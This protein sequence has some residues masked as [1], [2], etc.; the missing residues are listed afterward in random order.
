MSQPVEIGTLPNTS[1]ITI[2]KLLSLGIK[3]SS[4]LLNYF[5]SRYEN[6]SLIS[7]IE[8]SRPG[9]TVT[10]IGKVVDAKFQIARTGLRIQNFKLEDDT[11]IIEFGFFNQPYLLRVI[12][13]GMY[14]SVSGEIEIFGRKTILK[15]KEYEIVDSLKP[16]K[17]LLKHTGRIIPIYPEKAGLSSKT[18]REKIFY[19]LSTL[20]PSNRVNNLDRLLPEKI[21]LYNGLID[22]INAYRNI[23]YPVDFSDLERAKARLAFDELFTIQL[24]SLIVKRSWLAEK[25]TNNFY[26]ERFENE[27]NRLIKGLPFK[28]TTAQIR[29]W[30]EIAADLKKINPMNRFLQGEVGSGKTIV[31]ALACYLCKLNGY[32]SVFMAPTEILVNQHYQTFLTLFKD[33]D[34]KIIKIT[35]RDRPK[36]TSNSAVSV[37]DADIIIGTSAILNR[38]FNKVGLVVIDEQ[39][40][41]GVSQRAHLKKKGVNPHLL[42]MTATPIPRTVALTLYGELDLSVI[43]EMPKNRLPVKTHFIP[44]WKRQSCYRWIDEQIT[45]YKNQVY[46]VCPL[47]EESVNETMKSVKA[48]NSEFEKLKKIFKNR[49]IGLLHGRM[50]ASEKN[51]TMKNFFYKK[52]DILV[53]TPVVEVGIDIKNATIILIEAAERYGLASLHQLRGRVGRGDKQS[54]CFL[55]TEKESPQIYDRLVFFSKTSNGNIL[56]EK[57]LEVRGAGNIYGTQQHGFIDLKIAKLTDFSLIEETKKAAEYFL[58]NHKLSDYPELQLRTEINLEKKVSRD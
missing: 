31:A 21:V 52:Y 5:P 15:P 9:E 8:N 37:D 20:S 35:G 46:I 11:G 6:F 42:T 13:P 28:L 1:S 22:E 25:T 36:S 56:A 24:A 34:T 53:T 43:D 19:V 4:D 29:A 50:K 26:F 45:T 23:H 3:N 2:K 55:F 48:A 41:F 49:S 39:H 40:R 58:K 47:I 7:N 51:E 44:T 27:I 30:N 38:N 57:D 10:I 14:F 17:S 54:Y 12:K 18:I 16:K 33:T 32:Q